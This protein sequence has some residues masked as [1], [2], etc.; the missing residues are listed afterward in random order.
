MTMNLTINAPDAA[1]MKDEALAAKNSAD[2]ILILDDEGLNLATDEMNRMSARV[3]E[4]EAARKKIT[5]PLDDAKKAVMALFKPTTEAYGDAITAIKAAIAQY[6]TERDARLAKE[7]AEAEAKAA[8]VQAELAAQA[9]QAESEAQK[10]AILETAA[11]VSAAPV[12]AE[13][14]K[15]SGM[16]T[17][18]KWCAEV[19]DKAAYLAFVAT[20]PELLETV[21]IRIASIERYVTATGNAVPLPGI[22]THQEL[23]VSAR[24]A[25]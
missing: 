4:L 21:D 22:K 5:K 16:S 17:R 2:M 24:G 23:I 7:R 3:K 14:A 19:T 15:V 11:L 1:Q 18:K 6:V 25:A 9:E 13:P 8:A 20:H 10:Q 12:V